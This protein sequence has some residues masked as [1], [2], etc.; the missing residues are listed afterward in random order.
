MV[1]CETGGD[2]LLKSLQKGV[3][4]SKTFLAAA[5]RVVLQP[6]KVLELGER[7]WRPLKTERKG[8]KN[9][10]PRDR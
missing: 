3:S 2:E 8:T 1:L 9:P 4:K 7:R 10:V 6:E 5:A